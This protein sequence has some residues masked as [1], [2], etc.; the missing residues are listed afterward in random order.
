MKGEAEQAIEGGMSIE[1]FR[2]K[3][4][5]KFGQDIKETQMSDIGL[6][7]KEQR[8]YSL[9]KA[10]Y[11]LS[12]PSDR[13]AQEAAAFEFEVSNATSRSG[14]FCV[15][16][17]VAGPLQ[18]RDLTTT[19]GDGVVG[20]QFREGDFIE[21]LRNSS[22]VMAAGATM[23]TGLEGE[24]KIP[25]Q[26][27]VTVASFLGAE[28]STSANDDDPEFDSVTMTGKLLGITSSV[29]KQLLNTG[30]LDVENL[31]RNDLARSIATGIDLAGLSGSGAAGNPEGIDN[32]SGIATV[33]FASTL[34]TFAEVVEL[35]STV[36]ADNAL[37]GSPVYLMNPSVYGELKTVEK[38]TNTAEFIVDRDGMINGYPVIRSTQAV[39]QSKRMYFGN[40]ADLLIG[41][42]GPGVE[43]IVDP[44]SLASTGIVKITATVVMDVAVRHK[45]S[46]V[47]A[48]NN[49]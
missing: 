41:Q 15:P 40:F 4:H 35:E 9:S 48:A 18:K 12:N 37:M 17:E 44:F 34:P 22:A 13:R 31:I 8:S 21:A 26:S 32:I 25:R 46:F 29:T 36:A 27:A 49:L 7:N 28:G 1:D 6:T 39:A 24:I 2:A 38:A 45:E 43:I 19:T 16:F 42:F 10:L 3:I 30:S 33:D 23:L 20:E 14:N 5:S 47:I 11:A